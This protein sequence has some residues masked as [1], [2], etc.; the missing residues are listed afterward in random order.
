MPK[1]W[2]FRIKE[3][4]G[5]TISV[6][7]KQNVSPFTKVIRVTLFGVLPEINSPFLQTEK[8]KIIFL[9]SKKMEEYINN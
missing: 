2:L 8:G 1:K 3:I 5:L 7:N 6:R 4:F 9:L